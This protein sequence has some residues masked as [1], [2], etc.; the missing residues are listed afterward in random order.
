MAS[1][2]AY[3][4]LNLVGYIINTFV[5]FLASPIFGFPDNGALSDKYQTI[6][7]PNGLTFSIWGI[8]FI[9]EA[10]FTIAQMFPKFRGVKLVQEGVSYWYFV[11]RFQSDFV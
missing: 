5:T 7:T 6:V 4:Y 2:N 8:I 10:V 11:G 9:A 3:N 1:L